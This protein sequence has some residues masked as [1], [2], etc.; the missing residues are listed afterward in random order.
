MF[1]EET[2]Y[3]FK[4]KNAGF[5]IDVDVNSIIYHKEGIS[6][7]SKSPSKM[8]DL[9]QIRNR[10]KFHKKYLGGGI[11]LF[12][13]LGLVLFNRLK[14]LQFDRAFAILKYII[15]IPLL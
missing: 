10:I 2:D 3:C 13:S 5:K 4:T 8:I 11:G 6:T 9:L 14:R 12:F 15:T 1:Y 7:G